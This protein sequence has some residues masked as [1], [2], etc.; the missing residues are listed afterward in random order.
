[1]NYI[2]IDPEEMAKRQDEDVNAALNIIGEG[3]PVFESYPY[4]DSEVFD[5]G[6]SHQEKELPETYQ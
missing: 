2:P 4:G 3:S 6:E 1:M 5:R